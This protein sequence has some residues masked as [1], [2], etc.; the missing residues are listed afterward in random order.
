LKRG[1]WGGSVLAPVDGDYLF[2]IETGEGIRLVVDGRL[3]VGAWS[4]VFPT[5]INGLPMRL[6]KGRRYGVIVEH[7]NSDPRD[8]TYLSTALLQA[9]S[10]NIPPITTRSK[11]DNTP[12]IRFAYRSLK[13]ATSVFSPAG[14]ETHINR[15]TG[16]A[17]PVWFW[18]GQVRGS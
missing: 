15:G 16:N 2:R 9:M 6:E 10:G 4:R 5:M 13:P 17:I 14:W 1:Q 11:H 8:R 12:A 18:L 7:M 3:L